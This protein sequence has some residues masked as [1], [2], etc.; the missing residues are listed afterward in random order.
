[1]GL[2]LA[3]G[4]AASSMAATVAL[5]DPDDVFSILR[6]RD[7]TDA[8]NHVSVRFVERGS[9]VIVRDAQPLDAKDGCAAT[10]PSS[11]RVR[12]PIRRGRSRFAAVIILARLG[13]GEDRVASPGRAKYR[14]RILYL[15]SDLGRGDDRFRGSAGGESVIPGPGEDRVDLGFGE[16]QVVA[17]PERDGTDTI[18]GEDRDAILYFSRRTP[19]T[20]DLPAGV[21]GAPGEA[22]R[23]SDIRVAIGGRAGDRLLGGGARNSLSGGPGEDLL[24]GRGGADDLDGG[25]DVDD[26]RA[27]PG[28][29]FVF[30]ADRMSEA[31]DCGAGADFAFVDGSD[32]LTSCEDAETAGPLPF[33]NPSRF[34]TRAVQLPEQGLRRT[35]RRHLGPLGR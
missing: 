34:A 26:Y 10:G 23:I 27:G 15:F 31:V 18:E 28:R 7:R 24:V 3:H 33:A 12:C 17:S 6:I 30:A 4:L 19:V 11:T 16:D 1:L 22:D 29:D 2:L 5:P 20:V 25:R 32:L 9:A 8:D 21:A 13:R 14:N 35:L